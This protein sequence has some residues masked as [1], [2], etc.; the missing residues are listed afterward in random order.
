MKGERLSLLVAPAYLML[1]IVLG[2]SSSQGILANM[3]LQLLGVALLVWASA[4]R[5]ADVPTTASRQLALL[6]AGAALVILIHLVPLPASVWKSLPGREPVAAG[7]ATLGYPLPSLPASLAPYNTMAS[8]RAVIPALVMLVLTIRLR[9]RESWI[10]AALLIAVFAAVLLGALQLAGGGPIQDTWYLYRISSPGAV[11][12]F[13]NTN[14]MGSLLLVSIPFA[15]ALFAGLLARKRVRSVSQGVLLIGVAALLVAVFGLA[16]NRSLAALI[17]AA[18]V[19][20]FSTM[21]LPIGSNLTRIALFASVFL[22]IVCLMVL[23][24]TAISGTITDETFTLP[25]QRSGMWAVT[26]DLLRQS[27]P[28]GTGLGSFQSVYHLGEDPAQVTAIYVNHAHNDYLEFVLELGLAGALLIIAFLAWWL[29]QVARIWRSPMSSLY[30]RAATIAS[31]ALLAHSIVDYPLRTAAL[32]AVF[33]LCLGL[34]A[35]PRQQQVRS[36]AS[37]AR[38]VRHVT[39]G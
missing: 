3:V 14:H 11:G 24:T 10:A 38:P 35:Q 36:D 33:A 8:V 2:G 17:I 21:L 5:R 6:A 1:C 30:V 16:L 23:T 39:I 15:M 20:L 27:F 4:S 18:P 13:A 34:M 22:V 12:F 7:F 32:S 25:E 28:V 31:G 29:V 19:L 9:Q 26:V 37:H